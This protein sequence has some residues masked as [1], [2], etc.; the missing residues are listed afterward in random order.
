MT[1]RR[2]W[3]H[4]DP[5]GHPCTVCQGLDAL[6]CIE[7]LRRGFQFGRLS[8]AASRSW[9]FPAAVCDVREPLQ[10]CWRSSFEV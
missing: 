1:A 2:D 4:T 9:R 7:L 10:G 6:F 5:F 3:I 8:S